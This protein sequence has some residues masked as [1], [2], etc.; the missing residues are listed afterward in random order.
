MAARGAATSMA[1]AVLVVRP[2]SLGDIVYALAIAADIRR[3]DPHLAIDWVVERAATVEGVLLRVG[4]GPLHTR[5]QSLVDEL[6]AAHFARDLNDE[7]A[8]PEDER[9]TARWPATHEIAALERR[10]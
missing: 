4:R 7:Q 2:S 9:P 6:V 1:D 3:H 8:E 10:V 5:A